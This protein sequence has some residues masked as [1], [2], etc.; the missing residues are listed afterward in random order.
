[1][2]ALPTE[3]VPSGYRDALADEKELAAEIERTQAILEKRK[4]LYLPA[5]QKG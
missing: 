1:L 4:P 5:R 3:F 2:Q